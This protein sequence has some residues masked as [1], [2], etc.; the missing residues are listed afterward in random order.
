MRSGNAALVR[1]PRT[2][3][4]TLVVFVVGFF[5]ALIL[6]AVGPVAIKRHNST[7][8]TRTFAIGPDDKEHHVFSGSLTQ[9]VPSHQMLW[10][11]CKIK[12]PASFGSKGDRSLRLAFKVSASGETDKG[13]AHDLQ[14]DR[15]DYHSVR[16]V[17]GERWCRK[18]PLFAQHAILYPKYEVHASVVHAADAWP[19]ASL[20][21]QMEL[22]FVNRE[23]TSFELGFYMTYLILTVLA[24]LTPRVGYVARLRASP[25]GRATFEQKCAVALLAALA[26]LFLNPLYALE[27]AARSKR[28]SLVLSCAYLYGC[29]AFLGFA[30]AYALLFLRGLG[31]PIRERRRREPAEAFFAATL[32]VLIAVLGA[33]LALYGRLEGQ[34]DPGYDDPG[35]HHVYQATLVAAAVATALYLA[36]Y[37]ACVASAVR[38]AAALPAHDLASASILHVLVITT[39]V[40][41]FLGGY[42]TVHTRAL[43]FTAF[44][45]A[46]TFAVWALAFL[47][48][49]RS[50]DAAAAADGPLESRAVVGEDGADMNTML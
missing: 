26:V 13:K 46:P 50:V 16:C 36:A 17:G 35:H 4:I 8:S 32:G 25:T 44:L 39:F 12:R 1:S 3:G 28:A 23:Y 20:T 42:D 41:L 49:P 48:A 11:D 40:G 30:L 7:Y 24:L 34:G 18:V 15:H 19:D 6:G 9:M 38:R 21:T 10:L 47:N 33:T 22:H 43:P 5:F 27:L 37:A 2:S 14:T 29:F 31:E 45:S